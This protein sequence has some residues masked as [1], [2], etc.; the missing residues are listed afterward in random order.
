MSRVKLLLEVVNNMESLA[1]SLH[2][3]ADAISGDEPSEKVDE[4]VQ[5]QEIQVCNPP[6]KHILLED[7]RAVL[8]PISQSGKTA[9]VKEL[10]LKYGANRLSEIDPSQYES[11]LADAKMLSHG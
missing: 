1:M 5:T 4:I 8:T 9:Q 3:L 2:N 6:S 7:V 11:L 10:L